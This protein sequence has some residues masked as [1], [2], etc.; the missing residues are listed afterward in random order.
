M[1]IVALLDIDSGGLARDIMMV[2]VLTFDD[3]S[4]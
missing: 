4:M 1:E 3:E 2:D